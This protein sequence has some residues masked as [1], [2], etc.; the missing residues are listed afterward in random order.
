VAE[1]GYKTEKELEE[2]NP[3]KV[4]YFPEEG[5]PY[6]MKYRTDGCFSNEFGHGFFDEASKLAFKLF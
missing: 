1:S 2:K 5:M 3:F 4:Y 6:D